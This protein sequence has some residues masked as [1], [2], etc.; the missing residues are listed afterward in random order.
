MAIKWAKVIIVTSVKGG[1]GK[2]STVLN[3]AGIYAGMDK[4]VLV[5]DMD[6]SSSTIALSLNL[7]V[8][9]DL[10]YLAEDINNNRFSNVE[11]YLIKYS[12]NINILAAPKDPRL[13][14]K[15][16]SRYLKLILGK[17][18][19]VYDVIILDTIHHMSKYTLTCMD[20]SDWI[21]YLMSNDPYDLKNMKSMIS[22]LKDMGKT[23]Y[24]VVL[25]E[26]INHNNKIFTK[27]DIRNIIKNEIDFV[28]PS[29]FYIKNYHKYIIDGKIVTMDSKVRV[30]NKK[31]IEVFNDLAKSLL[32]DNTDVKDKK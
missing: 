9:K 23:N 29:S 18:N 11:D 7:D 8:K 12:D 20:N 4:K 28:I 31:A 10:F 32:E 26:S 22:I 30:V 19:S 16:S 5:I 1:V 25:N 14:N 3:L 15:I 6:L 13:E 21:L 27:Y 17:V 2:T 24:K